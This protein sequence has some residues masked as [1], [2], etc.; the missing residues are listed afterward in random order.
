MGLVGV[1]RFDG[2]VVWFM[3]FGAVIVVMMI[4]GSG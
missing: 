4:V 3:V 2:L 1:S